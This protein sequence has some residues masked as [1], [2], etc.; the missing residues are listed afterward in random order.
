MIGLFYVYTHTRPDTN[1]V[2]YVGKGKLNRHKE[3]TGRSIHWQNVIK[4]NIG[5]YV[6]NIVSDK[7]LE[8]DAFLYES[9]LIS[10]YGRRDLGEGCLINRTDGGDGSSGVIPSLETRA[11]LSAIRTGTKRSLETCAKIGAVHKGR[12]HTQSAKHNMSISHLGKKLPEE[13]KQK[14]KQWSIDNPLSDEAKS[15][16]SILMSNRILSQETKDKMRESQKGK[17]L[18]LEAILK[19]TATRRGNGSYGPMSEEKKLVFTNKGT[20]ASL[21]TKNK[22]SISIKRAL[23]ERK[24]RLQL[25]VLL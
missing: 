12:K 18:T 7:L 19:R 22:M 13:Q 21:E 6:I 9:Y 3:K 16:I 23:A 5:E 8:I 17:K 10:F 14:I 11:K 2:F 24:E 25:G 1:E 20:K 4:A 15:K